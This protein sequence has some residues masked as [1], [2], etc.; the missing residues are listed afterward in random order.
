MSRFGPGLALLDDEAALAQ[1]ERCVG[2]AMDR[3]AHGHPASSW[4]DVLRS[5]GNQLISL[6]EECGGAPHKPGETAANS[7]SQ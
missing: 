2:T 4:A 7:A 1:L 6:S 5:I 3:A